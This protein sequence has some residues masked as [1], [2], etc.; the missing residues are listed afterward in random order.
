MQNAFHKTSIVGLYHELLVQHSNYPAL[1]TITSPGVTLTLGVTPY[2]KQLTG[3]FTK[4]SIMS[5]L[6]RSPGHKKV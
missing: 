4:N 2:L 1:D 6:K 3:K 5:T